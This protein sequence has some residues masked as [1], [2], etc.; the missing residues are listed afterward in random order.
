MC[1]GCGLKSKKKKKKKKG[2]GVNWV[3]RGFPGGLAV[4]DP[5]LSLLGHGLNPWPGNLCLLQV[6]PKKKGCI[7]FKVAKR[8][9]LNC[10]HNKKE[11]IIM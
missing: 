10:S 4:E 2:G 9:D 5:A 7:N 1:H 8:P 6:W 11:M 3:C